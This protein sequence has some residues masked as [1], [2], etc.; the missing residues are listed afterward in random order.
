MAIVLQSGPAWWR[1]L[2]GFP[3]LPVPA[4]VGGLT[5]ARL[6]VA[7]SVQA[8]VPQIGGV[9]TTPLGGLPPAGFVQAAAAGADLTLRMLG[10]VD[11]ATGAPVLDAAVSVSGTDSTGA[12]VSWLAT[13]LVSIPGADGQWHGDYDRQ[14]P[15]A[16]VVPG[17]YTL[18]ATAAD[19]PAGHPPRT[20]T[21]V[22]VVVIGPYYG[23]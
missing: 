18:T 17:R 7:P 2:A 9:P 16:V 14:L 13:T 22:A 6:L 10:L 5:C 15:A 3:P 23:G 11:D 21:V 20:L 4:P 8:G 12:P 1:Q 19:S